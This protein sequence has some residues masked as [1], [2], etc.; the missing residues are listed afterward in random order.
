MQIHLETCL[1]DAERSV[2]G[3]LN[4]LHHRIC[5]LI[6]TESITEQIKLRPSKAK[7]KELWEDL[8]LKCELESGSDFVDDEIFSFSGNRTTVTRRVVEM[9]PSNR[10]CSH[11]LPSLI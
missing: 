10:V 8:K 1:N 7:K 11:Y 3:H 9:T 5:S 6:S 4:N 2:R